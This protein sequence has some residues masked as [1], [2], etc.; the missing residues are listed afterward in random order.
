MK[1][2]VETVLNE[3]RM[4]AEA[5]VTNLPGSD[6]NV[7]YQ[8]VYHDREALVGA[9]AEV[10]STAGVTT[11]R[12][13]DDFT[14]KMA[15]IGEGSD[16][17]FVVISGS[18]REEIHPVSTDI[19]QI[20]A[21]TMANLIIANSTGLPNIVSVQRDRGQYVKPRT[22][23]TIILPSGLEVP[24]YYGDLVNDESEDEESRI[25][26]PGRMVEGAVQARDLE[27]ELTRRLGEHIPAAHEALLL[28]YEEAF[29]REDPESGAMYS[30][31]GD[32]LWG[33]W[34]TNHPDNPIMDFLGR[35]QN[36]VGVKIG[37]NS[38]ERH[39]AAV[40]R[41]LNPDG[42]PGKTMYMLRLEQHEEGQYSRIL[43]A[44]Q[45]SDPTSLVLYDIH[46]STLK[47]PGGDKIRKVR[48]VGSIMRAIGVMAEACQEAGVRFDGLHIETTPDTSRLECIDRLDQIPQPGQIDPR[49]NPQ[50]TRQIIGALATVGR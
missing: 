11:P 34:R 8:P 1:H 29:V 45:A 27:A 15:V 35:I 39:I 48:H 40:A 17:G 30:L 50:Q 13:V 43:R 7:N 9:V 31:S 4:A 37:G 24:A 32:M 41:K 16:D 33:G 3:R 20:A 44:I 21:T 23:G 26:D 12:Q 49:L 14:A 25:P 19:R 42:L 47:Q 6:Y 46:G 36:T 38:D 28:A 10:L 22:K 5:V 2:Q 18:C